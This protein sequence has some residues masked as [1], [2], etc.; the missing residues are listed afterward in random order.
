MKWSRLVETA[1]NKKAWTVR[2]FSP[3]RPDF[4]SGNKASVGIFL[5]VV[6]T[7]VSHSIEGIIILQVRSVETS[8]QPG[9]PWLFPWVWDFSSDRGRRDFSSQG[10]HD[11]SPE[12]LRSNFL[13][14]RSQ[15]YGLNLLAD[16]SS[17]W[18]F[19]PDTPCGSWFSDNHY[20]LLSRCDRADFVQDSR[21]G[22]ISIGGFL[23]GWVAV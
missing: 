18:N 19:S 9:V 17:C 7:I 12:R 10:H 21:Q 4:F 11:L 6:S 23:P 3:T 8:R 15:G 14:S 20:Q 5:K 2:A 22:I 13:S 16:Y 1:S